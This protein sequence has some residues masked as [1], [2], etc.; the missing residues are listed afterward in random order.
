MLVI[1]VGKRLA[2][3]DIGTLKVKCLVVEKGSNGELK[4]IKQSSVLTLLG[5]GATEKNNQPKAEYLQDTIDELARCKKVLKAEKVEAV[6]VV[7]TH[8]LRE[9]GQVGKEVAEKIKKKTGLT[10]EIISQQ[11]EA[12][13]FYRAV[14]ADFRTDDDFTIMDQGGGSV[15]ILI[16]NRKKLKQTFLLKTGSSYM[17][18]KFTPKHT[19]MDA[20]NRDEI[21][22]M[23][24]Y[25][26]E[27]LQLIPM[28]LKTPIVY[29]STCI[30]DVFKALGM[31]LVPFDGSPS[32]PYKTEIPAMERLLEKVW[33]IP[34]K[35]R[36][37]MFKYNQQYYMWGIDKAFLNAV[38]LARRVTAPYVIPSNA[39][40]NQG[41]L[42]SMV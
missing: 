18:S 36:D 37:D 16:G 6:R 23:E 17:W 21:R 14:L 41:L 12:E 22:Q 33:P 11:E 28:G 25:V 3:I 19:D 39:N 30:I 2:V 35:M 32:H 13:L 4:T 8:A 10:V 7:S 1:M 27:Q 24:K 31:P 26:L 9:M 29:G 34:Y 38:E 15:Q 42:M 40:I 5:S 20:P